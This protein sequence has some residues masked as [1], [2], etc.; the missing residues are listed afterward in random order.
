MESNKKHKVLRIYLSNTDKIKH[1]TIYE[2]IAFKAREYG[3]AGT[4]VYKG[5][6]GYGASSELYPIKFWELTEKIPIVIEIIDEESKITG[7]MEKLRPW[8][9][10]NPKGCLIT[11]QD[12]E[13]IMHKKG[14][15]VQ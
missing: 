4:T 3:L 11:C 12:V 14:H 1:T 5:M 2:A 7:F 6:M 8:L 9:E 10:Q 15:A 13:I